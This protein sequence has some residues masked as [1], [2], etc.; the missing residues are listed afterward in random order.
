MGVNHEDRCGSRAASAGWTPAPKGNHT[1]ARSRPLVG[2]VQPDDDLWTLKSVL[3]A[4]AANPGEAIESGGAVFSTIQPQRHSHVRLG[5]FTLRRRSVPYEDRGE[6][7]QHSHAEPAARQRNVNHASC[8]PDRTLS[9]EATTR[10]TPLRSTAVRER[11]VRG[12]VAGRAQ[13]RDGDIEKLTISHRL[14][15][16]AVSAIYRGAVS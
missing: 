3:R 11:R 12:R 10:S 7:F 13:H 1:S 15:V 4:D 6:Y 8:R 16:L 9:P 5:A 2:P 14:G